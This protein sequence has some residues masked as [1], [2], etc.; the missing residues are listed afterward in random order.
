MGERKITLDKKINKYKLDEEL[1]LQPSIYRYW[2]RLAADAKEERD[3]AK[4]TLKKLEGQ[5]E[6]K[7][8]TGKYKLPTDDSGKPTK[9]TQGTVL[10]II[11]SDDDV[12]NAREELARLEKEF[13][14][15]AVN[16]ET[17]QIKRSSLKHL[18][19]LYTK[20]YFSHL[21]APGTGEQG[22]RDRRSKLGKK[23]KTS[24]ED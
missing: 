17:I 1:E 22:S 20:E 4:N 15:A 16:E 19:E 14:K 3:N 5:I 8:W 24:Q 6:V 21:E 12:C 10:A 9:L 2:A 23:K 7:I 18:T 11:N 13:T